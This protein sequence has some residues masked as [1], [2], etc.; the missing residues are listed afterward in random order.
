MIPT[1]LEWLEPDGLGGFASGTGAGIRTRR[2][3]GLLLTA[4][5]PPTGRMM[6]VNGLEAW[7]ETPSGH[8]ALS[9][10]RYAPDVVHPDGARRIESFTNE[11]WPR[12]TFRLADGTLVEH[13]LLVEPDA[14]LTVVSWR[15]LEP[16]PDVRLQVRPFL[17]GRDYHSLHHENS[18]FRFDAERDGELVTWRPYTGV[19]P[20]AAVTNGTY[21][22]DPQWYRAFLYEEERARGLDDSEDLASPGTFAFTLGQTAVMV[23][24]TGDRAAGVLAEV[25]SPSDGDAPGLLAMATRL[26]ERER[27]RRVFASPLHRAADSFLVRRG[28]GKTIVAGYPWFTDWGRDTFIALRGL[29]LATGRLAEARDILVGWSRAVSDGMLPNRFPDQ[30]DTPEFN[31]VDASLWYVIAVGDFLSAARDTGFPVSPP[32]EQALRDG[33]E[34]IVAGY[35]AGTRYGIRGDADGLLACG[36]PG[37]QLTW[38]DAKIGDW[39]VTPR[40]GKPVEIQ[41]LW[42]NA[43]AI[44][45]RWTPGW[46]DVLQKGLASFRTRF[47]LPTEGWL[48]DVVDVDHVPGT[49]DRTCRPNQIFAVGGLPL[50]L[51]DEG[52][53]ARVVNAVESALVTP[54]GLRSL[55]PGSAGYSP[56]YEGDGATRDARYHQGTVWP[57]LIGPFVEAWL[58]VHGSNPSTRREARSRFVA[59]L[60]TLA[61][62][63]AGQL[64]EI[65]DA[66]PPHTPRGCPSQAWSVAEVL[67]VELG[68][69]S[70][71]PARPAPAAIGS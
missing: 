53:A 3:H 44:A 55:A 16:N 63:S 58:R 38:M 21:S 33:V 13:E 40:V 60:L 62:Q 4:T 66:D 47:W 39:V 24:T 5:T 59:P 19:P 7:I 11:P 35:A 45:A 9:S 46:N 69:L 41:A 57:W 15:L 22:A 42:L 25:R 56:T 31:S 14:A 50:L 67:R 30:G 10:Q 1:A 34:A 48:A 36:E 32:D 37:A 49:V 29:C 54:M 6:L 70:G 71:T 43:L 52:L 18:A 12:W 17:S 65:A 26:H 2:Y 27:N 23:L 20:I 64:P 28:S 8:H 61:N 51:I 68:A